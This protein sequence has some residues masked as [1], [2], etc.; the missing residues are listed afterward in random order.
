MSACKCHILTVGLMSVIFTAHT[1]GQEPAQVK[2]KVGVDR[3]GDLLPAGALTR[4]GTVR[5]RYGKVI[6]ILPDNKTVASVRD[7]WQSRAIVLWEVRT[8]RLIREIDTSPLF[9]SGLCACSRDSKHLVVCGSVPADKGGSRTMIRLYEMASG[10]MVRTFERGP[11]E[12]F[13]ALVFT[14]EGDLLFSQDSEG[15]V[16]IEEV[17]TGTELLRQ[18][19]NDAVGSSLA[20]SPNGSTLAL[21]SRTNTD[22]LVLWRWQ[23]A[24]EPRELKTRRYRSHNLA[25]SRDGK[26]LADCDFQSPILRVWDVEKGRVI[27]QL[28]TPSYESWLH[29]RSAFSPDGKLLAAVG[30][31][32]RG[33]TVH[34]WDARTG[35]YLRRME[36]EA[37]GLAFSPDGTLLAGGSRIW[38]LAAGKELSTNGEAHREAA[39]RIV[40]GGDNLVATASDDGTVRV[41]DAAT[42]RHRHCLGH[43]HW[44]RDIAMSPDGR[45]LASNSLDDTVCLWDVATGEKIYQL[46][47]H[48]RMGGQRTVAFSPDGRSFLAWGDDL[49]LRRWDVRTGKALSEHAIRPNGIN[50]PEEGGRPG[51]RGEVDFQVGRFTP[52]GKYLILQLVNKVFLFDTATGK[53]VRQFFGGGFLVF[54]L[55]ISPDSKLVLASEQ[56][57]PVRTKLPDGKICTEYEHPVTWWD[58]TTGKRVGQVLLRDEKIGPVAFAPDGKT[59]AVATEGP[60]ASILIVEVVSGRV[61]HT[62]TGFR[63]KVRSLAFM[64]DGKRLVSGMEDS[65]A[66]VWDLKR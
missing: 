20:V 61:A 46:A 64:P 25:F 27:H 43:G 7:C 37:N 41:W 34:L 54:E 4:L 42:G 11:R 26:R 23:T 38:D 45:H 12:S 62:I 22:T 56:G 13:N 15:N 53:E 14:P 6:A 16:G 47:G 30:G 50:V 29:H 48:G 33:D 36:L 19:F 52:D 59:F 9:A 31:N 28:E 63:G 8:G 35:K 21:L 3:Y 57:V 17:T 58:L 24:E 18:K 65:S 55:S 1:A 5:Y 51:D 66:L 10:K 40:T 49:Y 32:S 44:V 2:G 60:T 39:N